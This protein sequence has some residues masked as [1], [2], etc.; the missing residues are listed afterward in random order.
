MN[1]YYYLIAADYLM[2]IYDPIS[3]TAMSF[4]FPSLLQNAVLPIDYQILLKESSGHL[5]FK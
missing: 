2:H 1:L 5:A 4:S 3:Q